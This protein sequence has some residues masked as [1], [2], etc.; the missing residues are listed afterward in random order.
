MSEPP[1]PDRL[2][3]MRRTRSMACQDR[4]A[5]LSLWNEVQRLADA[6]ESDKTVDEEMKAMAEV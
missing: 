2:P 6:A 3:S 5:D 4:M 1:P